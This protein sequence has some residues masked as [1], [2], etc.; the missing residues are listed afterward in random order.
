MN[1]AWRAR[2]ILTD[3]AGTWAR[4]GEEPGDLAQLLT[5]YVAPLA[6]VP[7]VFGFIGAWVVGAVVP[8]AGLVRA[9]LL[10]GLF[11]AL[12]GYVLAC[13]SVLLLGLLIALL[14]PMFG[15][16]RDFDSAF[17]LAAYSSTPVWLAG[18]FLLAPGLR[19]LGLLGCYG[20]YLLWTGQARLVRMPP[21]RR[22]GYAAAIVACA[23]VLIVIAA[24][25]Q[26]ALFGAPGL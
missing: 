3:P 6:V 9:S 5:G 24:A 17:K 18:V 11:G 8:N 14:A 10:D 26:R 22:P 16:R 13:A 1:A 12:F 4:I 15:A 19:F 2:D 20:I 7:A 21:R 23:V 25:A